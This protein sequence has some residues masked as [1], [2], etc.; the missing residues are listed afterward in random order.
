MANRMLQGLRPIV[1][2]DGQQTRCFSD[3]RDVIQVLSRLATEPGIS[4]EVYNVG[5]DEEVVNIERLGITLAQVIDCAWNPI[6]L[7]DRPCEVKHAHCSSDKIRR[8]FGYKTNHSLRQTLESLVRW[9][10]ICDPKPFQYYLPIEIKTEFTPRWWLGP[11]PEDELEAR[12][13]I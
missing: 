1:Y 10:R 4:G 6:R 13:D 11:L 2:G 5:P 9:I 7:P 8:R 12:L 3:V